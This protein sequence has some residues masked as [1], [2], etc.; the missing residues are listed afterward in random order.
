MGDFF[1]GLVDHVRLV[2][3][4]GDHHFEHVVRAVLQIRVKLHGHVE[5]VVPGGQQAGAHGRAQ[6][7]VHLVG[8]H[9]VGPGFPGYLRGTVRGTVV[10][11]VNGN[12]MLLGGIGNSPQSVD[13]LPQAGFLVVGRNKNNNLHAYDPSCAV[14]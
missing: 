4:D 11:D 14:V 1:N 5:S 2:P 9:T 13:D 12:G 8:Q 10:D 6:S 3:G 7:Q